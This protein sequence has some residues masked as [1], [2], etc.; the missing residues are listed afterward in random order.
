MGWF[1]NLIKSSQLGRGGGGRARG[2]ATKE[3]P[4]SVGKFL[5][6]KLNLDPDWVW[7]LR[8]VVNPHEGRNQ[9]SDIR[10]FNPAAVRSKRIE[11]SG[12]RS[13]D[14]HQELILFDGWFNKVSHECRI[15]VREK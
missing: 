10:V 12:Y 11:V 5:V 13:L 15:N 9:V 2:K 3:L 1:S 14:E 4:T 7:S 8:C 6:T